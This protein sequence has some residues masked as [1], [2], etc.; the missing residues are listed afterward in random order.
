LPLGSQ[1][2]K[3]KIYLPDVLANSCKH[4]PCKLL[5]WGLY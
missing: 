4:T 3:G 1:D 5:G 2:L